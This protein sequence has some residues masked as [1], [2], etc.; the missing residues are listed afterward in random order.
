M[1]L[2]EKLDWKGLTFLMS[3]IQH[4]AFVLY[5]IHPYHIYFVTQEFRRKF[6]T[7][8]LRGQDAMATQEEQRKGQACLEELAAIVNR[9]LIRRTSALLSKYLPVKIEQ[10]I[11]IRLTDIQQNIYSKFLASDAVRKTVQGEIF[12]DAC[13]SILSL[14]V[15]WLRPISAIRCW[16]GGILID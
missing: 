14:T 8:I 15:R 16:V 1:R 10:V 5:S 12:I 2:A 9:C 6:E 13:R 11:C 4:T 3:F 7:P